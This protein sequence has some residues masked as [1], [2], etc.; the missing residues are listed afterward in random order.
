MGFLNL[1]AIAKRMPDLI[2]KLCSHITV[3]GDWAPELVEPAGN[4]LFGDNL[5]FLTLDWMRTGI[6]TEPILHH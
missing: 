6:F 3:D 2:L 1:Q 5:R 4:Q